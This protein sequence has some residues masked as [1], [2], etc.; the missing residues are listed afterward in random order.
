MTLWSPAAILDAE[1]DDGTLGTDPTDTDVIARNITLYRRRQRHRR[2]LRSRRHRP[3]VRLP[4]DPR[5]RGRRPA[6]RP[7][8]L[9]HLRRRRVVQLLFPPSLPPFSG[10]YGVFLTETVGDMEIALGHLEGRRLALDLPP[11]RSSTRTTAALGDDSAD[12]IGNTIDLAAFGDIGA[13]DGTNDL[14]MDSQA[15]RLRHASARARS[16]TST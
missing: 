5:Q 7:Q 4:R 2:H 12:V 10:T 6:R 1:L 13:N 3:A 11:A 14:E 8:R 9:R 16:A 15:L